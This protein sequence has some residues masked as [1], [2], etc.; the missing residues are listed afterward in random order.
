MTTTGN[1]PKQ[2]SSLDIPKAIELLSDFCDRGA[3]TLD[4]DFK[5]AVRMAK[6]W[7]TI[8][9][10]PTDPRLIYARNLLLASSEKKDY[11]NQR[12]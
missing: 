1:P 5:D 3:V 11:G 2:P 9:E 12:L 8:L 4:S 10:R 6:T 7:L